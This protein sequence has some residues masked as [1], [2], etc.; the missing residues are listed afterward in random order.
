M[1]APP[2]SS[3]SALASIDQRLSALRT[4]DIEEGDYFVSMEQSP[5]TARGYAVTAAFS[6]TAAFLGIRNTAANGSGRSIILDYIRL[7]TTVVPASAA[8]GMFA[9][10]VDNAVR[11]SAGSALTPQNVRLSSVTASIANITHGSP[12]IA[13]A[14]APRYIA[15]GN[16]RSA[17]PVVGDEWVFLFGA[18]N[19]GSG[20]VLNGTAP[21]RFGIP[22]P[23]VV[24]GPGANHS[25]LLHLWFP[26]NVT[27]GL[28]AIAEVGHYER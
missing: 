8:S 2:V 22:V 3:Q 7:I 15:V 10:A 6:A 18:D 21:T 19:P 11:A 4:G 5:G 23:P 17:I 20:G 1:G 13:A 25:L 9:L 12:T 24:L 26:S 16:L 27:T 28:S 14:A